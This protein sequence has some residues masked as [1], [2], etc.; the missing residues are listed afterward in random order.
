MEH[1]AY[2]VVSYDSEHRATSIQM[3]GKRPVHRY[4]F[5]T[6][7]LGISQA[8][9]E[10]QLGKPR[11]TKPLGDMPGELWGYG[12]FPFTLEIVE[13]RLYSVKIFADQ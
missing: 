7:F 3:T 8:R 12:P 1:F 4:P 2:F 13:G 5:S 11:E 6:L 9:V 10:A